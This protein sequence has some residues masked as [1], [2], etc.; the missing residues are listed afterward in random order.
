[1]AAALGLVAAHGASAQM[2]VPPDA[3]SSSSQEM[4]LHAYL[5]QA[6]EAMRKGDNATAA[7]ILKRAL[8]IDPHS[9]PAL[10]NLAIV[11]ARLGQ[12]NEAIPLYERALKV[13]PDDP[14]TK[15]NLAIAYFKA[16]RYAEAWRLLKTMAQAHSADFQI[17]ELSGLALFALDRYPEAVQYLERTS[18]LQPSDL[19]T[20]DVL[21]KAYLHMKDYKALT[22]VFTRIMEVNPDSAA[23]HVMMGT[24]YDQM[25]QEDDALKEFQAAAKADRNFMGVHSGLALLYWKQGNVELAE[26]EFRSELRRFPAD[27]VSNRLLGELFLRNDRPAEAAPYFQKA[28]EANR[29]DRDAIFDLA[30]AELD[31]DRPEQAVAALRRAIQIDPAYAEAHYLLSTTLRRLGHADEALREQKIFLD[32]KKSENSDQSKARNAQQPADQPEAISKPK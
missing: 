1:V 23:G 20:L 3:T 15:R 17:L 16:Q 27:P 24:A 8:A 29:R 6:S 21:G 2:G 10:N 22:S 4:A 19:E 30:K 9:V 14:V 5:A 26:Q 31:M 28:L 7:D 25:L 12:P 32:L 13:R 11:L 18:R